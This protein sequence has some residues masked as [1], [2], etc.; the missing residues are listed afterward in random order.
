MGTM[1]IKHVVG[2]GVLALVGYDTVVRRRLLDWGSTPDER[3]HYS[4]A[5]RS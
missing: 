5:M 1:G 2:L 4:R 3:S